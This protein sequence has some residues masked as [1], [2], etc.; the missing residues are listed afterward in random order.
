MA[1]LSVGQRML[2]SRLFSQLFD[3]AKDLINKGLAYVD[4]T[5]FGRNIRTKRDTYTTR[6]NQPFRT[7]YR[8]KPYAFSKKEGKHPEGAHVLRAKIDMA[9]PNMLLRDPLCIEFFTKPIIERETIG[10]FIPCMIGLM[11]S[12]IILNNISLFVFFGI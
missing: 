5:I 11:E 12:Q 3:W 2:C 6:H 4:L 10:V 8:R 9:S 7:I 1:G